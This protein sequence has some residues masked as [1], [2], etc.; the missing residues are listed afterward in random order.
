[1]LLAGSVQTSDGLLV[2]FETPRQGQK[3]HVA[4]PML[5]VKPVT[6]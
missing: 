1:V 6:C 4:P 3:D 2:K 5:Q